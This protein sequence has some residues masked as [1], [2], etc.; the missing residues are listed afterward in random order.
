MSTDLPKLGRPSRRDLLIGGAMAATAGLS[1]ARAPR[2]RIASIAP[3]GLEKVVPLKI[4]PWHYEPASGI[5]LPPPDALAKLLYDQQISRSY[6]A[7][8]ELPIMLVAAYGSS[9]GGA[10]QVHRPE[11]C[12]PASGFRLTDTRLHPLTVRPGDALPARFFTATSDTRTEQV[13]YWTRIGDV[14]PTSWTQQRLAI[15]RNNL[16]G[17]IPDGLLLRVS[18][19][20]TDEAY[21]TRALERFCR[22][23]LADAG[24]DGRRKLVG[25]AYA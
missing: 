12:Y 10:L 16:V 14:L 8:N 21:A 18:T 11:I 23:L 3:G 19:I 25:P 20:H 9:Q 6:V 17:E 4:G 5:V 1:W 13:L 24:R 15:M 2:H 22:D 7:D